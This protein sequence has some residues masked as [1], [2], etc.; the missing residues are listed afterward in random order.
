MTNQN[1]PN[2]EEKEKTSYKQSNNS[3][4][5]TPETKIFTKKGTKLKELVL[6]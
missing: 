1:N 5:D 6:K 3:N 4:C 2:G